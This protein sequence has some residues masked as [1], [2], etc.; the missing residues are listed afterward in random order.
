METKQ[1]YGSLAHWA[2]SGAISA[3]SI[4][5]ISSRSTFNLLNSL[6]SYSSDL[7]YL[8]DKEYL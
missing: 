4:N 6:I 3:D 8:C 2:I 1:G 5:S 7:M